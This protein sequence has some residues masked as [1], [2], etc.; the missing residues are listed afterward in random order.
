MLAIEGEKSVCS[1]EAI[2]RTIAG[3]PLEITDH[4]LLSKVK[5]E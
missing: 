2:K 5:G 3:F 1:D 4:E